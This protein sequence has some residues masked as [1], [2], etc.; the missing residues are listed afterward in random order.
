MANIDDASDNS[1]RGK[2]PQLM[3]AAAVGWA[4]RGMRVFPLQP[5]SKVPFP[6]SR[7]C[8]DATRDE[9]KIRRWWTRY[10]DA[11]IGI[12]TGNGLFV[13][14]LDGQEAENWYI[15][16]LGRHGAHRETLTV[17]TARGWHLFFWSTAKIP[18]SVGRLAPHIDV[19]GTGGSVVAAPSVHPS[20]HVYELVKD[21]EIVE[22][23]RWLVDLAMP[24]REPPRA[25]RP[26]T[27][28]CAPALKGVILAIAAA[29]K[30][31]RNALLYWGACCVREMIQQDK[32]TLTCA[33]DALFAA[34]RAAGLYTSEIQATI[35]SA[36]RGL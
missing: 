15:D 12:A 22:A 5:R 30:G 8:K 24:D 10:P 11:N 7:G 9:K 33:H 31:R 17:S 29:P 20:G 28:S 25:P 16:A 6:G 35:N 14:D 23:P 3:L 26:Y 13:V 4:D 21:A 2:M 32:I 27:G 36:F 19:R 1:N 34:G 18:N